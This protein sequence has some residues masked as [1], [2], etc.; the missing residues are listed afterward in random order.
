M[1]AAAFIAIYGG[2]GILVNNRPALTPAAIAA[3]PLVTQ[4]ATNAPT[5]G[6]IASLTALP[7]ET[8]A[9]SSAAELVALQVTVTPV[10]VQPGSVTVTALPSRAP[11]SAVT[12]TGAAAIATVAATAAVPAPRAALAFDLGIQVQPPPD[13]SAS[14]HEVWLDMVAKQLKLNWVKH[15]I[16]WRDLE[17]T[18]GKID[19]GIT[20]L[21]LPEAQKFGVKV[22]LSVVTA[23][24]WAREKGIAITA[25]RQGP[26][27]DPQ[28]Y[29]NFV[30][31]IVKKYPGA[32]GAIE[33][34]NEMNLDREWDSPKGL[35]PDQY[36]A[37]L[38]ATPRCGEGH[39]PEHSHPQR[40]AIAYRREQPAEI[41]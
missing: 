29:V 36:V 35:K 19:F 2:T 20:D 37:L 38:K 1:G 14:T 30:T 40:R 12:A 15:Q 13:R 18:K 16:R 4:S 28:D 17:T 32:V 24:D 8:D 33:V 6:A 34:W 41:L 26:P 39:R 3:V 11:Q 25:D 5:L 9:V 7:T 31:A 22:L 21:I 10:P 23:P 27:A